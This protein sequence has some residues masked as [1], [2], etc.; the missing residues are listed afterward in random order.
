MECPWP[1]T[2][3]FHKA[4]LAQSASSERSETVYALHIK[5]LQVPRWGWDADIFFDT[6]SPHPVFFIKLG[7]VSRF[8]MPSRVPERLHEIAR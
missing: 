8:L 1:L 4:G 2:A 3:R 7:K 6:D 5:G